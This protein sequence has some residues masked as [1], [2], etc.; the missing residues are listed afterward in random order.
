MVVAT[1]VVATM[2]AATMTAIWFKCVQ[3]AMLNIPVARASHNKVVVMVLRTIIGTAWMA[4]MISVQWIHPL[5]IVHAPTTATMTTTTMAMVTRTT[6]AT[7]AV[8]VA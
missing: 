2:V 4:G 5:K 1:M 7:A 6:T 8:E 3:V